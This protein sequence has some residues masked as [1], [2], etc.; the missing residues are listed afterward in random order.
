MNEKLISEIT[1]YALKLADQTITAEESKAINS[2]L[3]TNADAA[4]YYNYVMLSIYNFNERGKEI[5]CDEMSIEG[6]LNETLWQELADYEKAAQEIE[7]HREK[8]Q[9]ELIQ[10]VVYPPR[11]KRKISKLSIFAFLNAAAVLLL[12]LIL[13]FSPS[14][15]GFEVATL[16]DSLNVKWADVKG[17]MQNGTRLQITKTPL[18]LSEGL[19]E[20]IFDNNAKV[21]I[22]GPS[23]FRILAEDRIGLNYGKVYVTVPQEA[24]GFSVY[25]KHAKIIDLGTEFGV[26]VNA[27]EDVYLHVVKGK[28]AL[29]VGE[30][31][32]RVIMDVTQGVAKKVDA[33]TATIV[34]I[35]WNTQSYVRNFDSL[36]GS[37]WRG[38]PRL[39]LAD[40]AGGGNGL[41]TGE[42]DAGIN[43]T[44]GRP[45]HVFIETQ[46]AANDF[47]AVPFNPYIDGVFV[48]DGR[49]QQIIS[50][51]GHEFRE[52]PATS[53]TCFNN[54]LNAVRLLDID[55]AGAG[56]TRAANCLLMHANMGITYDLQALRSLFPDVNFV[57]FQSNFGIEKGAVRP[58]LSNADFWVLVDGQLR[59]Q[60]TQVGWGELFEVQLDLAQKDRFLTLV[61][62]DGGD[63]DDRTYEDWVASSIHSDWGM[64][65]DPVLVL[66]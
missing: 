27:D 30:E 9:P 16:T 21:I 3:S 64:F 60:K 24:I 43:P 46:T 65:V 33:A 18:F 45:A 32:K 13:R 23:V 10:K 41:E 26:S 31:S 12:L 63:P 17:S 35:P 6:V 57:R 20:L 5:F 49:T 59:F 19:A 62:T 40:I 52:C 55:A 7:I 2:I 42:I 34:D 29:L 47:R 48:P 51:Q 54:V 1:L 66:E 61:I 14:K 22:E 37:V 36:N 58:E 50:S 8:P 39:C 25:A 38:Q 44:S 56:T 11:E 15:G 4:R 53:G 28:T